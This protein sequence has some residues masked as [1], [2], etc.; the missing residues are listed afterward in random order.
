MKNFIKK[1]LLTAIVLILIIITI[2]YL[3]KNTP[4]IQSLKVDKET[5]YI[6]APEI[7]GIS[8]W[9][10]SKPLTIKGLKGNV[11]MIDFWTYTCINCIRT[12][13]HLNDWYEKYKDKG[14]VIIGIHSPEFEFEK[15]YD[16]VL[17]AVKQYNIKYPV[18]Q[19][20]NYDVWSSYGNRFW[21]HEYLIDINGNLRYD[22]IGEGNYDE[23]EKEIQNLLKERDKNLNIG[24][25]SENNNFDSIKI[26]T[27][28]IYLGYKTS[29]GNFGNQ[30]GF[31]PDQVVG[32]KIPNDIQANKVYLSG[33]W[34]NNEDNLELIG[35]EGT[36][37]LKYKAKN[38][39][40]VASAVNS[41]VDVNLD[42]KNIKNFKVIEP[43]LYVASETEDY[44][45]YTLM[46][47]IKNPGFK[48]YTF[49]FG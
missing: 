8:N 27:P 11:V 25:T 9:I 20:N 21:P 17:N 26:G 33:E 29:R 43:K 12:L 34:K 7:T 5:N 19:D 10:N 49:T 47:N 23:T 39:N 35:N 1:P 30:E 37:L 15:N 36:I 3:Q 2:F 13:P 44:G 18:A 46:L 16:N 45:E 24:L 14:L 42:N 4:K 31:Q 22:H 38:A 28:E 32:Y 6:K 41:L 40:I 48:I